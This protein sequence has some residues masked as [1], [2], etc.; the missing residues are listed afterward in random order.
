VEEGKGRNGGGGGNRV[1]GYRWDQFVRRKASDDERE[2][3]GQREG[4]K[5]TSEDVTQE[6]PARKHPFAAM[7][8]EQQPHN[9]F[10]KRRDFLPPS[11]ASGARLERGGERG[12]EWRGVS[13]RGGRGE[14]VERGELERLWSPRRSR[15]VE[16]DERSQRQEIPETYGFRV[17]AGVWGGAVH[18]VTPHERTY[19]VV[20]SALLSS[21][22]NS[23]SSC[24]SSSV[25]AILRIL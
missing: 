16:E 5:P 17:G 21:G 14:G 12:G 25:A 4:E 2:G 24:V 10:V 23:V 3:L 9:V 13:R 15:G 8:S 19:N 22:V 1:S 20:R 7:S 11:H 18:S 6:A